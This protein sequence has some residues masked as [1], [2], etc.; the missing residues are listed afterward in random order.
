MRKKT[1]AFCISRLGYNTADG[2]S[3]VPQYLPV[4]QELPEELSP[5]EDCLVGTFVLRSQV[6]KHSSEVNE[7]YAFGS[8]KS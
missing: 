1:K 5:R 8:S 6:G 3:Q 7:I 4:L 2:R